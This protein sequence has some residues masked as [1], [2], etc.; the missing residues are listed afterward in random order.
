MGTPDD[1]WLNDFANSSTVWIGPYQYSSPQAAEPQPQ[2]VYVQICS[3]AKL[4]I[5]EFAPNLTRVN[6][7]YSPMANSGSPLVCLPW[8][9]LTSYKR[10]GINLGAF[11]SVLKYKYMET[12]NEFGLSEDIRL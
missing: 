6:L 10:V 11:S 8:D 4:D 9:Q 7:N 3:N 12:L 1:I 5:F 2:L